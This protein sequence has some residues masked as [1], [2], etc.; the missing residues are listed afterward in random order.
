MVVEALFTSTNELDIPDLRL[1]MCANHFVLPFVTWG[2]IARYREM[3]GTWNFYADDSTFEPLWG[4]PHKVLK[5]SP[6]AAVEMN[7]SVTVDTPAALAIWQTYR[8]RWISRYWQ[9]LGIPTIV[10]LSVHPKY[11]ELNLLGVPAGWWA[12]STRGYVR[13]P[14]D[15]LLS[16]YFQA[17][18]I[19]RSSGKFLFIVYGGGETLK[20][21]Y[22]D[23]ADVLW[24]S[25]LE[26]EIDNN[27]W[28]SWQVGKSLSDRGETMKIAPERFREVPKP[29]IFQG[30]A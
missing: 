1:D 5:S 20:N 12:F 13:E 23:L 30:E 21:R 24:M 8:K 25:D 27:A 9:T 2:S 22:P 16:Q 26:A 17:K 7:F 18:E 15:L 29:S 19:A 10:D 11:A 4:E 3:K 6:G 28:T 14:S